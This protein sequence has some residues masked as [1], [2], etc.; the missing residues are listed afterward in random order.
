MQW[1][2]KSCSDYIEH[3]V[4]QFKQQ[5]Q[6]AIKQRLAAEETLYNM[7]REFRS[8]ESQ[9]LYKIEGLNQEIHSL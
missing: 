4:Q 7:E 9:Y 1:I 2:D 8:K 5:S 6:E 3:Q